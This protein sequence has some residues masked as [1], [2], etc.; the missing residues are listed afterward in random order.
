MHRLLDAAH[1]LMCCGFHAATSCCA[2]LAWQQGDRDMVQ[3][4]LGQLW[5]SCGLLVCRLLAA[6]GS[7][8]P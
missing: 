6:V 2:L 7:E 3:T 4:F 8:C 5:V 1:T